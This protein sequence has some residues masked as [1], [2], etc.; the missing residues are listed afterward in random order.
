MLEN[1]TVNIGN[2]VNK[3]LWQLIVAYP[4][5]DIALYIFTTL[6][7]QIGNKTNGQ[8]SR[9]FISCFSL[10]SCQNQL[11]TKYKVLGMSTERWVHVDVHLRN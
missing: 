9:A 3:A 7:I 5:N 11:Y 4:L 2:V 8:V 1:A 10:D 6:S